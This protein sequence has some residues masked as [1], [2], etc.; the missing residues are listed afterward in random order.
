MDDDNQKQADMSGFKQPSPPP[1]N[2]HQ[3]INPSDPPPPGFKQSSL[4]PD[5]V[6]QT[7]NPSYPPPPYNP[8]QRAVV[9]LGSPPTSQ[10]QACKSS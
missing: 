8:H 7:I 4:P 10:Q 5:S 9:L 6:H 2:V 1:C 3:T